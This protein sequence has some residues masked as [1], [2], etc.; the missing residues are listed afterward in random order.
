MAL[1]D[2]KRAVKEGNSQASHPSMASLLH[3]CLEKS[4][5]GASNR[6]HRTAIRSVLD[7]PGCR[8][9]MRGQKRPKLVP[10]SATDINRYPDH[11][12]KRAL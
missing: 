11:R 10:L 1:R 4:Y 7:S 8:A 9:A 6:L 12:A 3:T 2:A 5:L